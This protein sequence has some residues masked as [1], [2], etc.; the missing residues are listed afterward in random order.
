MRAKMETHAKHP[1]ASMV[2]GCCT[3][4]WATLGAFFLFA[5]SVAV[6]NLSVEDA[7]FSGPRG[8]N[9]T[10]NLPD[11]VGSI[12]KAR[13]FQLLSS[14][15]STADIYD[16]FTQNKSLAQCYG[17][18]ANE[19]KYTNINKDTG[20][21]TYQ[22]ESPKCIEDGNVDTVTAKWQLAKIDDK[23]YGNYLARKDIISKTSI[24]DNRIPSWRNKTVAD[25]NYKVS[26]LADT[27]NAGFTLTSMFAIFTGLVALLSTFK[28]TDTRKMMLLILFFTL[29]VSTY[30]SYSSLGYFQ[31]Q[32]VKAFLKNCQGM[33]NETYFST[34]EIPQCR[35]KSGSTKSVA[36]DTVRKYFTATD[37]ENYHFRCDLIEDPKMHCNTF[38]QCYLVPDDEDSKPATDSKR[39]TVA[40][41]KGTCVNRLMDG[42]YEPPR[43]Q[44]FGIGSYQ[45]NEAQ[46]PFWNKKNNKCGE[47]GDPKDKFS[48]RVEGV[49]YIQGAKEFPVS[50]K[51]I[52]VNPIV[53]ISS[54]T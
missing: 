23:G 46:L 14:F 39:S 49:T 35:V 28:L 50:K 41:K 19:G 30:G 17:G 3:L 11:P 26:P 51:S 36:E 12:R 40:L 47:S 34:R 1:K 9:P 32:Q 37:Y 29:M 27:T 33:S 18:D 24:R 48:D 38:P 13:S 44:I 16:R 52:P 42:Y 25:F 22:L 15:I 53:N 54:L 8:I 7:Y 2:L 45:C 31:V 43:F 20:C 5:G 6:F 10:T 21:V 4:C